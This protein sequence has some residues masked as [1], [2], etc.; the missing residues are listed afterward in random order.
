MNLHRHI[1]L[2]II[3][4]TTFCILAHSWCIT[5]YEFGQMYNDMYQSLWYYTEYFQW[6]KHPLCSAYSS[7]PPTPGNH[8]CFYCLCSFAFFR[9]SYRWNHIAWSISYW[10]I[11][12]NDM[13]LNF[14]CGVHG[15]ELIPFLM[16]NNIPLPECITYGRASCL[17]PSFG[18]YE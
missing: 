5:F 3:M 17:F 14:L 9:I 10:L 15:L 8:W 7:F 11:S 18:N 4:Q 12:L 13:H 2:H 6:T 16:L 1:L